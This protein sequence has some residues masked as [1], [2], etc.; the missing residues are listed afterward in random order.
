MPGYRLVELLGRG[1]YGE[2][3]KADSPN[4]PGALKVVGWADRAAA[5]EWRAVEAVKELRHPHVL[6]TLDAWDTEAALIVAM[7]LA[8][9]SLWDRF[10]ECR[11]QGLTG[12][13]AAELRG[14]FTQAAAGIDFLN[15]KGVQHRDIKPSNLLLVCDTVKVAD[16]GLARLL[17]H[18][19]TGHTVR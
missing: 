6:T 8:D 13:P 12:I 11:G 15:G 17:E 7:E 1:G 18:T 9:R 5:S 19:Q 10:R 4:G 2:V 14:H 3:W 16:F